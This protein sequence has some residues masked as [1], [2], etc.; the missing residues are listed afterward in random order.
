[1]F[2][3]KIDIESLKN[4]ISHKRVRTKIDK[5][6]KDIEMIQ[7]IPRE[8]LQNIFLY[9]DSNT[10]KK[11]SYATSKQLNWIQS[12]ETM[13]KE[14]LKKNQDIFTPEIFDLCTPFKGTSEF[15]LM[16]RILPYKREIISDPF[17]LYENL[18]LLSPRELNSLEEKLFT[19]QKNEA[20]KP[21][22][23]VS[24]DQFIENFQTEFLFDKWKNFLDWDYFQIIGGSL[25]KCLLKYSFISNKQD[26]DIFISDGNLYN[27]DEK[28]EIFSSEMRKYKYKE[29]FTGTYQ[30]RVRSITVD[31]GEKEITFQF[32]IYEDL[33]YQILDQ[34]CC[35]IGF[36]GKNVLVT[37]SFIQSLNTGTM[38]NYHLKSEDE[39]SFQA[40]FRIQKYIS[41]GFNFLCPN[42]FEFQN[43]TI[44]EEF[45]EGYDSG[46]DDF[47]ENTDEM[48]ILESV[49]SLLTSK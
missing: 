14:I 45:E 17:N 31:F 21:K 33:H 19:L 42:Q 30:D 8:I 15:Q 18:Y 44:G 9:L 24:Y 39:L 36:N 37:H 46:D 27:F 29:T 38:M 49:N 6:W 23:I 34:D 13:I 7:S 41:R 22:S 32:I 25:L 2:F 16:S 12:D 43:R 3:I 48:F 28:L 47:E 20:P 10:L 1:M 35:Q 40:D 26:V 11:I 4:L 5:I